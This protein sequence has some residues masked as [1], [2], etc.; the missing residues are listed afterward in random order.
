M[1]GIPKPCGEGVLLAVAI[2]CA[3][4]F[5]ATGAVIAVVLAMT[6][7]DIIPD[8]LFDVPSSNSQ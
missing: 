7:T 2:T 8:I 5:G 3:V 6:G 1:V 4:R